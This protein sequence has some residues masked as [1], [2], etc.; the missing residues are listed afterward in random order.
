MHEMSLAEALLGQVLRTAEE[1]QLTWV[2]AVEVEAGVMKMIV[3]EILQT[4]FSVVTDGTIA[5]GARLEIVEIKA[6]V[7]CRLCQT[8]F[9]PEIDNFLCPNCRTADVVV[10]SGFD[11][12][13][14][15]ITGQKT[16][17]DRP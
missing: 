8:T 15:S 4:A 11:F 9:E 5:Q 7:R 17:E 16:G 13:L 6:N 12:I 10:L 1:H 14:Q 3:P 2:E